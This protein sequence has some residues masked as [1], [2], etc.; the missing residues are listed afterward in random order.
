MPNFNF[1]D[2][3]SL[4]NVFT[5]ANWKPQENMVDIY[6]LV[7]TPYLVASATLKQDLLQYIKMAN[8]DFTGDINLY[9][10]L[11]KEANE[12]LAMTFGLSD[13]YIM[14][15]PRNTSNYPDE[16]RIVCDT[17]PEYNPEIHPYFLGYNSF[18]YDSTMLA[19]YMHE[20]FQIIQR[21]INGTYQNQVVFMPITAATMRNHNNNLFSKQFKEKMPSYLTIT[22]GSDYP[23][24]KDPRYTIRKNMM[25]SGRHIDIARLNEKQSKVAL[26]RLL[27]YLGYQIKESEKVKQSITLNT[28]EEFYELIAYNCSDIFGAEKLFNH[29][30]YQGQFSLKKGMLETYPE[31]IYE[32]LPDKY[33]PNISPYTVRRDRMCI[34]SSSAQFAIDTLCPYG[35]LPDIPVV[36]F[37]YPSKR[38]AEELGI[39]QINVLDECMKFFKANFSQYPEAMAA[40]ANIYMYYKNIEGKNFNSSKNYQA[41]W[42]GKPEYKE[43]MKISDIPKTDNCVFYYDK[44]GNPTSTFVTF[45]VGGI[46]G[47]EYNKPLYE[48]DVAEFQKMEN[49]YKFVKTLF[50]D[51]RQLKAAKKVLMPDGST[52][53]ATAFLKA[54]STL[55]EASYKDIENKRPALFKEDS[56]KGGQKLNDKYCYTS[57]DLVN[58]EDFK[59]YYPNLL[60]MLTAFFNAGLGYDRYAEIFDKKELYGEKMGD[61]T[62]AELERALYKVLREGTKLVM[63]SASGGADAKFEN[64]IIMN[65]NIIS[66]RIIGQLFSWRIGQAQTLKG[67]KITSTNT[68]GLYS[69]MD[70]LVLNNKILEDEAK[71]INIAIEP[72]PMYLISKDTNNR[73]EMNPVSGKIISASG[74]S[75]GCFKGPD[76]TKALTH[77]AILDWALAE[78]LIIAALG[79]KGLSLTKDMDKAVA[80][81][82][83]S[84]AKDKFDKTKLLIMFQNIVVSSIGSISYVFGTERKTPDVPIIL[85]H[86]NRIFLMKDDVP[87]TIN[88]RIATA[89]AIT[90]NTKQKR[91]RENERA[92]QHD[93][94]ALTIL[95]AHGVPQTQIPSDKEASIK[96]VTNIE[97]S[98]QV[99]VENH[100][101]H[102]LDDSIK[103]DILSNLDYNKYLTILKGMYETWQN[104][105]PA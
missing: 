17:D 48:F 52:K 4:S 44:D 43:P 53:P 90:P 27:G 26:K 74:G 81:N 82:I 85:Q 98:W 22:P 104:A 69:A 51:P 84:S 94:M 41:D 11:T 45:S 65:N 25:L 95:Q 46:H 103:D 37:M 50:P 36:S 49:E 40:F 10:L 47:A 89:K 102:L 39:E 56:G 21:Q 73:L 63:N 29:S 9:N 100:D 105:I 80:M 71:V 91:A 67:A 18:N 2:I 35:H 64:K 99:R 60:R 20:V 87:D 32:K 101:L 24:W 83:L 68:D 34:D 13:A 66:M 19:Q 38:K 28:K 88:I 1:Y 57:A 54:G 8:P 33:A 16:F 79:H 70:D 61:E 93:P 12:H 86:S 42:Y 62:I 72:E 31:L 58:H 77:P 3:E 5:L 14:N 75:L 78:Y 76:P 6:Y 55:K 30:F 15:N 23:D 97:P 59:S 96:K 7:D 92:I